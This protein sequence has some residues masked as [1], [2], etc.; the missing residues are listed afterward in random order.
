MG[1]AEIVK[2]GGAKPGD[3]TMI[4]ALEPALDSLVIGIKDA[5]LAARKGANH[6][7]TIL[8]A[9][10]GRASYVGPDQLSG[11][12]DPGAEAVARVFECLAKNA[13]KKLL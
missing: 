3:R 7:S 13:H 12:I 1:L 4:D 8:K 11:H 6:T 2:I 10:A 9:G 5:A